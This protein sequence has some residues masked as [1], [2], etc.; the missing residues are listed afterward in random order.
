MTE[1]CLSVHESTPV[2]SE[3]QTWLIAHTPL[4]LVYSLAALPLNSPNVECILDPKSRVGVAGD[5]LSGSS[6]E[7]ASVSG[8]SL[9]RR[10][11]ALQGASDGSEQEIGLHDGFTALGGDSSAEIGGFPGVKIPDTAPQKQISE[12]PASGRGG[13][14]RRQ[15]RGRGS[16]RGQQTQ[17]SVNA[18]P[19]PKMIPVSQ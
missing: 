16:G 9:A 2:N 14:N 3:Q 15:Q 12:R 5:W 17:D 4:L 1:V 7:A 8:I 19:A 10:L 13:S 18:R 6:M 11:A